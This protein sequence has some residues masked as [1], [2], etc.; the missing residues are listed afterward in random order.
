MLK[1]FLRPGVLLALVILL[2]ACQVRPSNVSPATATPDPLRPFLEPDANYEPVIAA[3]KS[4]KKSVLMEMYLL[5]D[6]FV[7]DELKR[8]RGRG[9]DV[10]VLLETRPAGG[11]T[12]NQPAI[13]EL[14][15][16]NVT[17][18]TSN[19]AYRLGHQ[20][21]IV[22]DERVALIMTL[23][24]ARDSFAT[25]REFGI[26]DTV[27]EDVAEI[28]SVFQADWNGN[29]PVVSNPN[30]VWSPMNAR[31]RLLAFIDQ[32]QRT[33]DVEAEQMQDDEVEAH[34]I[35]AVERGVAVRLVMSP[36]VTGPDPNAASQ[37]R[38]K[39]GGVKFRFLRFPRIDGNMMVSDNHRGFVGSQNF[40]RA[41]LD[42]NREL[43]MLITDPRIVEGLAATFLT[44]WDVGK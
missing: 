40:T 34:F 24:Q 35:S 11:G 44:D 10:R 4:A 9:V 22:V 2:I 39:R 33:L 38:L 12:G 27:P 16:A 8:A 29:V 28:V 5:T 26:V 36:S 21:T 37:Q 23:D 32:A 25:N 17:V 41:S 3:L 19:S 18:K 20:K 14:R 6:S 42:L 13:S 43:G 31:E 7:I 15:A 1:V 30:L